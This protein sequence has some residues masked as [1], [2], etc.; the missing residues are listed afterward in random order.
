MYYA[1]GHSW[2]GL[3]S[4]H[5]MSLPYIQYTVEWCQTVVALPQP[6]ELSEQYSNGV[7][8]TLASLF[9]TISYQPVLNTRDDSVTLVSL[10]RRDDS[11]GSAGGN[12]GSGTPPPPVSTFEYAKLTIGS[13]FGKEALTV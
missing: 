9:E 12:S 11:A 3:P 10:K 8:I 2:T 4:S 1:I 7:D 13:A 5:T 6:A